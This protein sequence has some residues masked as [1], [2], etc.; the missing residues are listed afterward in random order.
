MVIACLALLSWL[1]DYC[2]ACLFW[3]ALLAFLALLIL[4]ALLAFLVSV[5]AWLVVIILLWLLAYLCVCLAFFTWLQILAC[6]AFF[7]GIISRNICAFPGHLSVLR[8][9]FACLIVI[10]LLYSCVI[11]FG[12]AAN[13][14]KISKMIFSTACF[15]EKN[16]LEAFVV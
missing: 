16:N 4:I 2:L 1:C 9:Y 13:F 10:C 5:F 14:P 12:I 7:V 15:G 3:F 11:F 8:A 6:L